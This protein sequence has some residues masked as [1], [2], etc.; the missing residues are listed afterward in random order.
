MTD[1]A[2]ALRTL[3][4]GEVDGSLWGTALA[5]GTAAIVVSD[6][7]AVPGGV[8]LD[9]GGWTS[10][11]ATWHLAAAGVELRAEPVTD[12]RESF[13][14]PDGRD[15]V[16][17]VQ[18][19]CRVRGVVSLSG[20]ERSIDCV[21]TRSVIDGVPAESHVSLRAVAGWFG[22]EEA[23]TLLSLRAPRSSGQESDLVAATLF[24]PEGWVPVSDPRLS[25]TYDGAGQPTRVNLELWVEDGENEFP[26]RAAGEAAAAPAEATSAGM[27]MQAVPLRCHSRGREGAGVYVLATV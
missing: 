4:F 27:R 7:S 10:D 17:G 8:A 1:A 25:T 11:G 12:E 15:Q 19:L 22:P 3:S 20:A 2:P 23:F 16:S 13:P 21:G 26:R 5:A 24:D 9:T 6:G 18:E 14:P